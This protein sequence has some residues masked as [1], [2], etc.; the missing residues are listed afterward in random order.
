MI[1][2][3]IIRAEA[4]RFLNVPVFQGQMKAAY[5]NTPVLIGW[6]SE[7]MSLCDGARNYHG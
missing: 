3:I 4:K 1:R 6:H 5:S 2:V 7:V